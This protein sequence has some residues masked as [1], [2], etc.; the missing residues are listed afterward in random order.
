[1]SVLEVLSIIFLLLV[2]GAICWFVQGL[3]ID[4]VIKQAVYLVL[5]IA[6]LYWLWEF[7]AHG[8]THYLPH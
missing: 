3:K 4:L 5:F 2:A 1:M 8:T 6:G 7:I